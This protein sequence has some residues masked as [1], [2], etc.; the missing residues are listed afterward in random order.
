MMQKPRI[1]H[2]P[3]PLEHFPSL[4]SSNS[5]PPPIVAPMS[6]GHL[7]SADL[8]EAPYVP[9]RVQPLAED[10]THGYGSHAT[11]VGNCDGTSDA[12]ACSAQPKSPARPMIDINHPP[13]SL[14]ESA[15]Q[16][17]SQAPATPAT[18]DGSRPVVC[19]GVNMFFGREDVAD[20]SQ[21]LATSTAARTHPTRVPSFASR[22]Q[23]ISLQ[24]AVANQPLECP[25]VSD[26]ANRWQ[27]LERMATNYEPTNVVSG[28]QSPAPKPVLPRSFRHKPTSRMS[29][30]DM[31]EMAVASSPDSRAIH[32]QQ[33]Q[34]RRPQNLYHPQMQQLCQQKH[35]QKTVGLPVEVTG[36]GDESGDR[37]DYS[38]GDDAAATQNDGIAKTC[39][40]CGTSKTPL[41]RNGPPGPKSLCNACGIRFNKIRSGKR[42]ASPQEAAMLREYETVNPGF[43]KPLPQSPVQKARTKLPRAPAGPFCDNFVSGTGIPAGVNSSNSDCDSEDGSPRSPLA[44]VPNNFCHGLPVPAGLSATQRSLWVASSPPATASGTQGDRTWEADS[45]GVSC[46]TLQG[47]GPFSCAG[48]TA[49]SGDDSVHVFTEDAQEYGSHARQGMSADGGCVREA[50]ATFQSDGA[51]DGTSDVFAFSTQRKS[52]QPMI[53][54]NHPPSALYDSTSQDSSQAPATPA[55]SDGSKPVV[56]HGVNIFFVR[57]DVADASLGLAA[58]RTHPALVPVTAVSGP[59]SPAPRSALPHSLR[60]KTV[61]RMSGPYAINDPTVANASG[62]HEPHSHQQSRHMHDHEPQMPQLYQQKH[63]R[64]SV[65]VPEMAQEKVTDGDESPDR[66][67]SSEGDDAAATQS[68]GIA[69]TCA[70]CGT[71]KTPLWRNGPPG[72]KSLC[73]ACGI[74]FNKIRSGKRKASP[75]EAAMLRE[76]DSADPAFSKPLP[77]S[78][79]H[80]ARSRLPRPRA[81]LFVY[82]PSSCCEGLPCA[83]TSSNSDCGSPAG[84][85]PEEGEVC[86]D[87]TP[88]HAGKKACLWHEEQELKNKMDEDDVVLGAELLVS[89]FGSCPL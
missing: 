40:H 47:T 45:T 2:K 87:S 20:A 49:V 76:Y 12:F 68:N 65:C 69:K 4:E 46:L 83:A 73:N 31:S 53:D 33:H 11:F 37:W 72:P 75:Q 23:P 30:P 41:W 29:G 60:H 10:S 35:S 50:H 78:P 59:R 63:V 61:S 56:S 36:G 62:S 55:A 19:Q 32:S 64:K 52:S 77:Q 22:Q 42:K 16:E 44:M 86:D 1:R 38:E 26:I 18:S 79:V 82:M 88:M 34:N 58:A 43:A 71:S 15:S 25:Q 39:A 48:A 5:G 17:S 13:S 66:W 21:G 57:D 7:L 54:I 9:S 67:D 81:G 27:S 89:L 8:V 74:R 84:E 85:G 6:F 51:S 28:P 80:K 3:P 24:R 70:H 14:L